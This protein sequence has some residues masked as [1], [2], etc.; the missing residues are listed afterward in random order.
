MYC[1]LIG[2]K[3]KSFYNVFRKWS[4]KNY[5]YDIEMATLPLTPPSPSNFIYDPF[6]IDIDHPF[7]D[8]DEFDAIGLDILGSLREKKENINFENF[9][10]CLKDMSYSSL[11]ANGNSK[12]FDFSN[13]AE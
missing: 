1:L 2:K 11:F 12:K 8:E 5:G 10:K 7:E 6:S 9:I 3:P 13:L 4:K